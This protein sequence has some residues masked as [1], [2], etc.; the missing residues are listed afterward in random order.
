MGDKVNEIPRLL[1]IEE[2]GSASYILEINPDV[3]HEVYRNDSTAVEVVV[4]EINGRK[5]KK[6]T[7]HVNT[8]ITIR[9]RNKEIEGLK[10]QL[11]EAKIGT[12]EVIESSRII[13]LEIKKQLDKAYQR[14]LKEQTK[15]IA[16]Q[17]ENMKLRA[18]LDSKTILVKK[19]LKELINVRRVVKVVAKGLG[20]S[21]QSAHV[22]TK[23]DP[24]Y[25]SFDK[26]LQHSFLVDALGIESLTFNSTL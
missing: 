25:R 16:L 22:S 10:K 12:E 24:G 11:R 5:K 17:L 7:A 18:L 6:E 21:A 13:T 1:N 15:N 19:L 26:D 2:K 20:S 23:S 3:P 8:D 14:E 9:S 4:K